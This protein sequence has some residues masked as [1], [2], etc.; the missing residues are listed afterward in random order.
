M[1]VDILKSGCV[2]SLA[3]ARR[4][5]GLARTCP[6]GCGGHPREIRGVV[7]PGAPHATVLLRLLALPTAWGFWLGINIGD[8]TDLYFVNLF[9]WAGL[10]HILYVH[11]CE[12]AF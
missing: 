12:F 1:Y 9:K 10:I 4:R 3:S 5:S 7:P 8:M 11:E 2:A 6:S